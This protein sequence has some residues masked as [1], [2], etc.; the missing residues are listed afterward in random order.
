MKQL[1]RP[2]R[3]QQAIDLLLNGLSEIQSLKDEYSDWLDNLP[4][5]LQSSALY[6]KLEAIVNGQEIDDLESNISEL[7][8]LELPKGFGRD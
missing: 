6:E 7:E 1:S 4:E 2:K 8:G 5:N 3:W